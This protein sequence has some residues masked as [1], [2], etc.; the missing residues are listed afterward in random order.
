MGGY[1]AFVWSAWGLTAAVLV[2]IALGARRHHQRALEAT[3]DAPARRASVQATV[4][5]VK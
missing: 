5:E 4:E 2:W 1:G 3:R